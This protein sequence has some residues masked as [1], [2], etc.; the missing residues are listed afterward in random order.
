VGLG[1]HGGVAVTVGGTD[2]RGTA[3]LAGAGAAAGQ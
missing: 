3:L 2:G 1:G